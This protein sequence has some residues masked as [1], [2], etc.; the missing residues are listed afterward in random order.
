MI[1]KE[2][3][4][5]LWASMR[6]RDRSQIQGRR[7]SLHKGLLAADGLE[8]TRQHRFRVPP[9]SWTKKLLSS[10][11]TQPFPYSSLWMTLDGVRKASLP[12]RD[13]TCYPSRQQRKE[14][15]RGRIPGELESGSQSHVAGCAQAHTQVEG[16]P[17]PDQ[18]L[19]GSWALVQQGLGPWSS[20]C[21]A[22]NASFNMKMLSQHGY[23]KSQGN[24]RALI[25]PGI[26]KCPDSHQR[27]REKCSRR[28][29]KSTHL[30]REAEQPGW[31]Q[32]LC[33]SLRTHSQQER[34]DSN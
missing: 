6:Q 23:F 8:N 28:E 19:S 14:D 13:V 11:N 24:T 33:S 25:T 16:I 7:C 2:R 29:N 18:W 4:T 20:T 30:G 27:K 26:W 32:P 31:T 3:K 5:H 9:P 12:W 10:L 17:N 34:A 1:Y 15:M 21:H 22:S